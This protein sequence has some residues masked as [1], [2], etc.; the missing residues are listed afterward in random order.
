MSLN[1]PGVICLAGNSWAG[2]NRKSESSAVR[3]VED[4][5]KDELSL[6]RMAPDSESSPVAGQTPSGP[7][8]D[9]DA[10]VFHQDQSN[11]EGINYTSSCSI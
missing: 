7:D 11:I 1:R 9:L 10:P 8:S 4:V 5:Q 6:D 2:E 3:F